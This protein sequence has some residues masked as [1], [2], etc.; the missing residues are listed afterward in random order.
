MRREP[1]RSPRPPSPPSGATS[2]SSLPS[3]SAEPRMMA[4]GF[5]ISC[6]RVAVRAPHRRQVLGAREPPL[7]LGRRSPRRECSPPPAPR[8]RRRAAGLQ[9]STV[10]RKC[11]EH[12]QV[13]EPR[14]RRP[15]LP[16]RACLAALERSGA[17]PERNSWPP[18]SYIVRHHRPA[19]QRP[20]VMA[21]GASRASG[22]ASC[23][24]S[25]PRRVVESDSGGIERGRRHEPGRGAQ[26]LEQHLER[27]IGGARPPRAA[28]CRGYPRRSPARRRCAPA[29][30]AGG[31]T[32][33]RGALR[34]PAC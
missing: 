2:G 25:A 12:R 21:A 11:A 22:F 3:R 24:C 9:S 5:L 19:R 23:W 18:T 1:V 6:A 15:A 4:S 29:P 28:G 30:P 8:C 14:V 31:R 17:R 16:A 26:L 33:R 13:V 20:L 34:T 27:E 7:E 32:R 10:R